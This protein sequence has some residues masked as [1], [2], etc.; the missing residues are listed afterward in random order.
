MEHQLAAWKIRAYVEA[1]RCKQVKSVAKMRHSQL[2]DLHDS[3]LKQGVKCEEAT[4]AL[5]ASKLK[6]LANNE[7]VTTAKEKCRRAVEEAAEYKKINHGFLVTVERC[8]LDIVELTEK[9]KVLQNEIDLLSSTCHEQQ[10]VMKSLEAKV[11]ELTTNL[12]SSVSNENRLYAEL[13]NTRLLYN[14]LVGNRMTPK[15]PRS[16]RYSQA[17]GF[18]GLSASPTAKTSPVTPGNLHIDTTAAFSVATVAAPVFVGPPTMEM[19]LS[20]RDIY[21][22]TLAELS[23]SLSDANKELDSLRETHATHVQASQQS[24]QDLAQRDEIITTLAAELQQSQALIEACQ[25]D[26]DMLISFREQALMKVEEMQHWQVEQG[27]YIQT[28]QNY[29]RILEDKLFVGSGASSST[30][31]HFAGP[32]GSSSSTAYSNLQNELATTR[33]GL[34]TLQSLVGASDGQGGDQTQS[35]IPRSVDLSLPKYVHELPGNHDTRTSTGTSEITDSYYY[36]GFLLSPF[37]SSI[38]SSLMPSNLNPCGNNLGPKK[39]LEA[40]KG[41]TLEARFLEI[42]EQLE[43]R[44]ASSEQDIQSVQLLHELDLEVYQAN[45]AS[46]MP[47]SMTSTAQQQFHQQPQQQLGV[48]IKKQCLESE[49]S[50]LEIR[51]YAVN[52][53]LYLLYKQLNLVKESV[54]EGYAAKNEC[55]RE[56]ETTSSS[57]SSSS[58]HYAMKLQAY[59]L[60]ELQLEANLTMTQDL[61]TSITSRRQVLHQCMVRSQGIRKLLDKMS[62]YIGLRQRDLGQQDVDFSV[63]TSAKMSIMLETIPADG[64]VKLRQ[65]DD[66]VD[67]LAEKEEYYKANEITGAILDYKHPY[68]EHF[69]RQKQEVADDVIASGVHFAK[70]TDMGG[71]FGFTSATTS[72]GPAEGSHLQNDK[73]GIFKKASAVKSKKT[74]TMDIE[75]TV[76][77]TKAPQDSTEPTLNVHNDYNF[78]ASTPRR[79]RFSIVGI[80][81]RASTVHRDSIAG[82]KKTSTDDEESTISI[83]AIITSIYS[84]FGISSSLAKLGYIP[85]AYWTPLEIFT[86][87]VIVGRVELE[88]M[89]PLI[90]KRYDCLP[91]YLQQR[92]EQREELIKWMYS[93]YQLCGYFPSA[94][95]RLESEVYQ[96]LCE[97]FNSSQEGLILFTK[98][99]QQLIR[100][101]NEKETTFQKY[102]SQYSDLVLANSG[103]NTGNKKKAKLAKLAKTQTK[104]YMYLQITNDRYR[105][106]DIAKHLDSIKEEDPMLV[107]VNSDQE[108]GQDDDGID[109][110]EVT[111]RIQNLLESHEEQQDRLRRLEQQKLIQRSWDS[112]DT[113]TDNDGTLKQQLAKKKKKRK[114]KNKKGKNHKVITEPSCPQNPPHT[115]NDSGVGISDESSSPN[116]SDM[117]QNAI[118]SCSSLD[119]DDEG[120][121]TAFSDEE[122]QDG[123]SHP[124]SSMSITSTGN[125]STSVGSGVSNSSVVVLVPR[126]LSGSASRRTSRLDSITTLTTIEEDE[127]AKT[128]PI[129]PKPSNMIIAPPAADNLEFLPIGDVTDADATVPTLLTDSDDGWDIAQRGDRAFHSIQRDSPKILAGDAGSNEDDEALYSVP[130]IINKT[131]SSPLY[132]LIP[133]ASQNEIAEGTSVPSASAGTLASTDEGLSEGGRVQLLPSEEKK[134]EREQYRA[135]NSLDR[136]VSPDLVEVGSFTEH[137]G[138]IAGG[139]VSSDLSVETSVASRLVIFSPEQSAEESGPYTLVAEARARLM[140]VQTEFDTLNQQLENAVLETQAGAEHLEAV[141]CSL[142]AWRKLLVTK[143]RVSQVHRSSLIVSNRTTTE[144]DNVVLEGLR[145]DVETMQEEYNSLKNLEDIIRQECEEKERELLSI[146]EEVGLLQDDVDQLER[147]RERERQQREQARASSSRSLN[148]R[149]DFMSTPQSRT[150]LGNAKISLLSDCNKHE[151]DIQRLDSFLES[152]FTSILALKSENL[153]LKAMLS[154][155]TQEFYLHFSRQPR[156]SDLEY[157]TQASNISQRR[158]EVKLELQSLEERRAAAEVLVSKSRRLLRKKRSKIEKLTQIELGLRDHLSTAPDADAMGADAN[159]GHDNTVTVAGWATPEGAEEGGFFASQDSSPHQS[160]PKSRSKKPNKGSSKGSTKR[161]KKLKAQR[162]QETDAPADVN[163]GVDVGESVVTDESLIAHLDVEFR[164]LLGQHLER[165]QAS[166]ADES[167]PATGYY[168]MDIEMFSLLSENEMQ[169]MFAEL[170]LVDI[171]TRAKFRKLRKSVQQLLALPVNARIVV[172]AASSKNDGDATFGSTAVPA[173]DTDQNRVN[174][175]AKSLSRAEYA[176]I[177]ADEFVGVVVQD[178]VSMI[179]SRPPSLDASHP[180]DQGEGPSAVLRASSSGAEHRSQRTLD[181][182]TVA[183][184][185]T[186]LDKL[187]TE[188]ATAQCIKN[189][190]KPFVIEWANVFRAEHGRNPLT[191]DKDFANEEDLE[192]IDSFESAKIVIKQLAKKRAK[193]ME[194]LNQNVSGM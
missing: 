132:E 105:M 153:T 142:D 34:T 101:F 161:G 175:S 139:S 189:F 179:S 128:P 51:V 59:K 22:R 158:N 192:H 14:D 138:D 27:K 71:N 104:Q 109:G 46:L 32:A 172:G 20:E 29:A 119:S 1:Y 25:N 95:Q 8:K 116:S 176:S 177:Y 73:Q 110:S 61:C 193:A 194:L 68:N 157:N 160:P 171:P 114:N 55:L 38:D 186:F 65:H 184:L 131:S 84:Q 154:Q 4:S 81:R 145:L 94:Q 76:V 91:Y 42:I 69:Q 111:A 151:A 36:R 169:G 135:K 136:T 40:V 106:N 141:Q 53:E 47:M 124:K 129:T 164:S 50:E 60:A 173:E 108:S 54:R 26:S 143:R 99:L 39:K 159:G 82:N 148:S 17:R 168:D 185:Q 125:G 150:D 64:H 86:S 182:S 31:P 156:G 121:L 49:L 56:L 15:T 11:H 126:P 72:Y 149:E 174:L 58:S 2:H 117:D 18:G 102:A 163:S 113:D 133:P 7:E 89:W 178:L 187:D 166:L 155:W 35:V 120:S 87:A 181:A 144:T 52:E 146:R 85:D 115:S 107:A 90:C 24:H 10:V 3:L 83:D 140:A 122:K 96:E 67:R 19:K 57:T 130:I 180:Q 137:G 88:V 188:I 30:A 43:E 167:K 74:G 127:E 112:E 123:S 162:P 152:S 79:S 134:L 165:L 191:S 12:S 48:D 23:A 13:E 41:R 44:I 97:K 70:D 93:F 62:A 92:Q 66:Y 63:I 190:H 6:L 98:E 5:H 100:I 37:A 80:D 170:N 147:E 78:S 103:R 28:C 33:L 45:S 77:P 16:S 21:N 183:K 9:N 118:R 75:T